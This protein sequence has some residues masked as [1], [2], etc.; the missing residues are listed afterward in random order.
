MDGGNKTDNFIKIL[1]PKKEADK[2]WFLSL[3]DDEKQ[4]LYEESHLKAVLI[5]LL[6][7]SYSILEARLRGRG[8]ETEEVIL[9]RMARAREE[10]EFLPNYD[11]VVYNRENGVDEAAAEIRAIVTAEKHSVRRDPDA[12]NR[13]FE[14]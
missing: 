1:D 3:L 14:N 12:K 10:L 6:P 5:M 7:P 4:R 11:Y 2:E 13:F 9:R 8:T